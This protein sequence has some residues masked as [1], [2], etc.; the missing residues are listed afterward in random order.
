MGITPSN[1]APTSAAQAIF[2]TANRLTTMRSAE[3]IWAGN[4]RTANKPS[5]FYRFI[6]HS[7]QA[8][9]SLTAKKKITAALHLI[10]WL[11]ELAYSFR[12]WSISAMRLNFTTHWNA[13]AKTI[14]KLIVHCATMV[15]TTVPIS[16]WLAVLATR[17]CSAVGNTTA[18][19]LKTKTYTILR[20]MQPTTATVSI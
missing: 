19:F 16:P 20:T 12:I 6:R 4:A 7:W 8:A 17:L 11:T 5:A 9:A 10:C 15:G 3:L 14:G 1:S 2:S 13:T 18:L